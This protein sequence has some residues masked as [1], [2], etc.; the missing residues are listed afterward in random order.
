MG[1]IIFHALKPSCRI[2][3]YF[4]C[5]IFGKQMIENKRVHII[6]RADGWVVRWEEGNRASRKHKTKS[7]AIAFVR[8]NIKESFQLIIHKI[9]GT[10]EEWLPIFDESSYGNL[11]DECWY[12]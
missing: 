3:S 5:E 2:F 12:G 6:K 10:I 1:W 4:C 9:D 8:D 7:E 11:P